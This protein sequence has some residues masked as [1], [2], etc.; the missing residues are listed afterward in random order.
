VERLREQVMKQKQA[1]ANASKGSGG[2]GGGKR[3]KAKDA[4]R[5]GSKKGEP[6]V[7][8]GLIGMSTTFQGK[9]LCYA[10]NL[11]GC[12]QKG[13]DR[14]KR[15]EHVCALPGCGQPHG[16]QS[17]PTHLAGKKVAH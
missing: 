2:M 5:A 14:C 9:P 8:L 7:P 13:V 3:Q 17:C 15:G 11:N 4:A 12:D 16:L 6:R 1:L 10:Y